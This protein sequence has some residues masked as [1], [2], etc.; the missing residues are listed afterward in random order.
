MTCD[1]KEA[2]LDIRASQIFRLDTS[3][4]LCQLEANETIFCSTDR[5]RFLSARERWWYLAISNC[6]T[7]KGIYLEYDIIMRNADPGNFF[8]EQFSADEINILEFNI[9]FFFIELLM[10][11]LVIVVSVKLTKM[12]MFHSTYKIFL[13]SVTFFFA[14][15]IVTCIAYLSYA[16]NGYDNSGLKYF[17]TALYAASQV[18]LVL[19]LLLLS[20]GY[21][22]VCGRLP[23]WGAI[24][25]SVFMTAF[26]VTYVA[27][28]IVEAVTFDPALVLY[29]YE[30]S[31]GYGLMAI[32]LA[33]WLFFL[34]C[35]IFTMTKHK[36]KTNFYAPMLVFYSLWFIAIPVT[37]VINMEKVQD[38][39]RAKVVN[40]IEVITL[41][42]AHL[43]YI[44]L[45]W[46]S[47]ANKNFPF[48]IKTTQIDVISFAAATQMAEEESASADKRTADL[49]D[50][51]QFTDFSVFTVPDQR[52]GF[53]PAVA[54]TTASVA[55]TNFGFG[56]GSGGDS[57]FDSGVAM[58]TAAAA[59]D[60]DNNSATVSPDDSVSG[61]ARLFEGGLHGGADADN[62]N[63]YD[64]VD[65]AETEDRPV[66]TVRRRTSDE[67]G[68]RGERTPPLPDDR[69][70]G[71]GDGDGTAAVR[72][73]EWMRRRDSGGGASRGGLLP[74]I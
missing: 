60:Y 27:L 22:V 43:F 63:S 71:N 45:T 10:V 15:I 16:T 46:P 56:L 70:D 47:L 52:S 36:K 24:C 2:L 55:A 8:R 34:G 51:R 73:P 38:H 48:H 72:P 26:V 74:P 37:V 12:Q 21:T 19:M 32:I 49:A 3:L 54:M 40:F 6:L 61:A 14:S 29:R 20:L 31:P 9:A 23:H 17:A 67:L 65:G 4:S 41:F 18:L 30:S 62:L 1:Q 44:V 33:S 53:V 39:M 64:A 42:L 50:G 25:L 69:L 57:D 59:D 35:C 5:I 11:I 13:S 7:T 28:Y 66:R 68:E 58:T